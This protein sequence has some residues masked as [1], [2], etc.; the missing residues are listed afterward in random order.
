[1]SGAI[2]PAPLA[3]PLMVTVALPSFTVAVATFGKV[4]VVMIA[5]AASIQWSGVAASASVASTPSN[6]VASSG[7]P[8]TPV[9]ARNTSSAVQPT[10]LAAICAVSAV[11]CLPV[12]P[13]KALA[14]P[15]LTTSARAC[16]GLELGAAPFHRRRR[17]FRF[18]EDAGDRRALVDHREQHVGAALVADAGGG[19]RE[20]H[21]GDRGHVGDIGRGEGGDG[22]GHASTFFDQINHSR[23]SAGIDV[24]RA[25]QP[26][27]GHGTAG[28]FGPAMT[29]VNTIGLEEVT[30][31][32]Y[33]F[34]GAILESAGLAAS[35]LASVLAA[36]AGLSMRSTLAASRSLAT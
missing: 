29:M 21:A 27:P 14:L 26:V 35:G 20:P 22:G 33:F 34:A 5:L 18:G 24:F 6:L 25:C 19:G 11:D 9:E 23:T 16:R 8:I 30:A 32:F 1:M 2:M 13:V 15:E 36:S 4:S 12:L 17:A 31:I 7:S 28:R 3:M 10:A